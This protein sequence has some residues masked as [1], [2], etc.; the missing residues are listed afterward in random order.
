MQDEK[1][2]EAIESIR[3]DKHQPFRYILFTLLNGIAYGLGMG[4]GMTLI[5]GIAV[6]I[7]TQMIANMVNVPVVGHYFQQIGLI[8]DAYSRSVGKVR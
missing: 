7:L 2:I 6:F 3:R 5:L 8:I 4:L 1:L